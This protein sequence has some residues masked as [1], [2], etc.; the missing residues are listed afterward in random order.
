VENAWK[1]TDVTIIA[2]GD[3]VKTINSD[4][5]SVT[6]TKFMTIPS[7][8]TTYV[9]DVELTL[10]P[11]SG[12]EYSLD[13]VSWQDSPDFTSLTGG[14]TYQVK[15]RY[16]T[17]AASFASEIATL[18]VTL[19]SKD[20][21]I[22]TRIKEDQT[23]LDNLCKDEGDPSATLTALLK[24]A[25]DAL[26][27]VDRSGGGKDVCAKVDKITEDYKL[28]L[29]Q[30]IHDDAIDK[31]NKKATSDVKNDY[32]TT[33]SPDSDESAK[34]LQ[35]ATESIA[36]VDKTLSVTDYQTKVEAIVKDC[37]DRLNYQKHKEEVT[38]AIQEIKNTTSG[39]PDAEKVIDEAGEELATFTYGTP[40]QGEPDMD[41][42]YTKTVTS[43]SL[44]LAKK[45]AVKTLSEQG[46][47][48]TDSSTM[49]EGDKYA[50]EDLVASYTEQINNATS[51]D[52]VTALSEQAQSA[53][54]AIAGEPQCFYHWISLSFLLLD[55]VVGLCFYLQNRKQRLLGWALGFHGLYAIA[56]FV[57]A[58]FARCSLC[59]I[60][61]LL[62][63]AALVFEGVYLLRAEHQADENAT[64]R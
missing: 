24:E 53:I 19:P 5:Q 62:S 7:L 12:V 21:L 61:L 52:E 15:A 41:T 16:K 40:K 13:G 32:A 48:L 27:N 64:A 60:V 33:S 42:L 56:L 54:G 18:D 50:V 55:I 47:S 10:A 58:F 34:I 35:K 37:Q 22:D 14:T 26:S 4:S 2:L 30:Q 23:L 49:D 57:L 1:G 45:S 38:K 59:Y 63:V 8:K 43:V 46:N 39:D 25:K 6:L 3:G 51:T 44:I 36:A 29:T 11:E 31:I 9:D 17:T 28:K 20:E